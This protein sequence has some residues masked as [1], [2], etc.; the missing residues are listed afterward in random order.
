M[1]FAKNGLKSSGIKE[2]LLER[3]FDYF[4]YSD[5][6]SPG[7]DG[8]ITI[9]SEEVVYPIRCPDGNLFTIGEEN[10]TLI[11][12]ILG[13]STPPHPNVFEKFTRMT[14][15]VDS[16]DCYEAPGVKI[17]KRVCNFCRL[18]NSCEVKE[19][20]FNKNHL[21]FEINKEEHIEKKILESDKQSLQDY[22][23]KQMYVVDYSYPLIFSSTSD[24]FKPEP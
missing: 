1:R 6:A 17:S 7:W 11:S 23:S 5:E 22:F 13:L 16:V 21:I 24:P 14:M 3:L 2:V 15:D 20:D 18:K 19:L 12:A 9:D 8:H 10:T 4:G